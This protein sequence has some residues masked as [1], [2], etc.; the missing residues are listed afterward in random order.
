VHCIKR[1]K[2]QELAKKGGCCQ[3]SLQVT[4]TSESEVMRICD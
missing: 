1:R 3:T 4:S 2:N